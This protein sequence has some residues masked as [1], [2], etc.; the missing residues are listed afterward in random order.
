MLAITQVA[1]GVLLIWSK[2]ATGIGQLADPDYNGD[3]GAGDVF[4]VLP[5]ASLN[6]Y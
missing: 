4:E 3:G 5:D 1:F 6:H 2:F